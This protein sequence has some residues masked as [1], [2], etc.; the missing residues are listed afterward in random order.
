VFLHGKRAFL[1]N[2]LNALVNA[3][4]VTRMASLNASS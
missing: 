1:L 2:A 4:M 3:R